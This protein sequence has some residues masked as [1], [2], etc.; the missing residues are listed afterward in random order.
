MK[1]IQWDEDVPILVVANKIPNEILNSEYEPVLS[2]NFFFSS[3]W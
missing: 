3:T 1:L 2:M